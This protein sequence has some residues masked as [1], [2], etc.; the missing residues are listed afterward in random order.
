[1]AR[2]FG[3]IPMNCRISKVKYQGISYKA[4]E[5]AIEGPQYIVWQTNSRR[6]GRYPPYDSRTGEDAWRKKMPFV[7]F[8]GAVVHR[9]LSNTNVA[10]KPMKVRLKAHKCGGPTRVD[11]GITPLRFSNGRKSS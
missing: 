7:R 2:I 3:S 6:W 1:M 10:I 11:E 8:R 4:Q 5:G 9:Y